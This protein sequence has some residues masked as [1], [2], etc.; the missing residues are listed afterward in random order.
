MAGLH[1]SGDDAAIVELVDRLHRDAQRELVIGR[2]GAKRSSTS[3]T[4]GPVCHA[5]DGVRRDA[6]AVRAEI[7][8]MAVA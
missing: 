4:V 2:A 8:M 5:I 7:G 6:V 1:S 3:S